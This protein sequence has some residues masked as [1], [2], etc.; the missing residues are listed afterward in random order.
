MD[1][2]KHMKN[3]GAND[4]LQLNRNEKLE[5]ASY[6]NLAIEHQRKMWQNH[7]KMQA[8]QQK[9]HQTEVYNYY[10]R[11]KQLTKWEDY[12]ETK[13]ELTALLIRVLKRKNFTRKWLKIHKQG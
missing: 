12:K 2:Y 8:A 3:G 7:V 13:I 9:A 11:K 6:R 1:S 4:Y 5:E 10:K